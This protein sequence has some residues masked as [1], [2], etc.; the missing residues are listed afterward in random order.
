[1]TKTL[2]AL[3]LAVAIARADGTSTTME[4]LPTRPT[5]GGSTSYPS[6]DTLRCAE[7]VP[8]LSITAV[9]MA[10]YMTGGLGG[11][12]LCSFTIYQPDGSAIIRTSGAVDCSASGNVLVTGLS[13][14][15]LTAGSKVLV[16]TCANTNGGSYLSA[17]SASAAITTLQNALSVPIG[18]TAGNPCSAAVPPSS[19]GSL[20]PAAVNVPVL[21]VAT[22]AFSNT[23]STTTTTTSTTTTTM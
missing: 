21:L 22:A 13:P 8:E 12:G 10:W 11:G 18:T 14:F 16:C 6:T 9:D 5:T 3:L 4:W 17:T 19:T 7:V 15:T 23:T 2:L 1:M 20:T